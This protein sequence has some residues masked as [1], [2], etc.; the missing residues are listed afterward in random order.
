[1]AFCS[2]RLFTNA[3]KTNAALRVQLTPALTDFKGHFY[4]SISYRWISVIAKTEYE[5]NSWDFKMASF[6]GGFYLLAG[7]NCILNYPRSHET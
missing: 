5:E 1:M 3:Q 2:F 6:I 4:P 7:F